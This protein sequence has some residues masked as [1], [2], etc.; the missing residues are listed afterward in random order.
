M[1][2]AQVH[3][4]IAEVLATIAPEIEL[5]ALDP[6]APLRDQVDLDSMDWL[7]VMVGLHDRLKIDIPESDYKRLMTLDDLTRYLVARA[8]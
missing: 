1:D 6:Q 7:N 8:H 2:T 4:T 5:D 3:K